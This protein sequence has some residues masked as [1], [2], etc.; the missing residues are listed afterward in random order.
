MQWYLLDTGTRHAAWNMAID[1]GL[2][3]TCEQTRTPILRFYQWENPTLSLGYFQSVSEIS[4]IECDRL[5]IDWIRRPTGGRAVLHADELTYSVIAP[6]DTLAKSIEASYE[7]LSEALALGLTHLGLDAQLTQKHALPGEKNPV[8]FVTPA[9]A[10]LTLRGK[11]IIG[12]AQMRTKFALLQHGSI[13]FT[14][15]SEKLVRVFSLTEAQ[16]TRDLVKEQAAGLQDFL[17]CSLSVNELKRALCKGFEQSLDAQ[18]EPIE[19][20]ESVANLACQLFVKK[21]STPEWN[22][23]R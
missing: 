10:E 11:K 13:P 2:L 9:Y 6:I 8:C 15:D 1:E 4:L 17:K 16:H 20:S 19:L 23:L 7:L 12:S 14:L 5:G 21:Y 22:A 18:F 3:L